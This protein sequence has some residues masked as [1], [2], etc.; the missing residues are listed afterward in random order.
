[1]LPRPP[2][3]PLA[4]TKRGQASAQV[5]EHLAGGGVLHQRA[6]RH[7]QLEGRAGR[8]RSGREPRPCSPLLA[9]CSRM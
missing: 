6:G 4:T 1:M 9:L 3:P 5:G 7:A 8:G 2:R